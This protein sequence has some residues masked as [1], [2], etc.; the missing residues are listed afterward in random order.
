MR[1]LLVLDCVDADAITLAVHHVLVEVVDGNGPEGVEPDG[2]VDRGHLG[3]AGPA[4]VEHLG[5]EV[6]AGGGG[7]HRAR[8]GHP[9]VQPNTLQARASAG[10]SDGQASSASLRSV[11]PN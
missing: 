11:S 1:L 4:P 3:A 7:G 10:R 5:G 8:A 2:E 6:E 9:A